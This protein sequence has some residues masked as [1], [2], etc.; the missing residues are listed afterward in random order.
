[1]VRDTGYPQLKRYFVNMFNMPD[2]QAA[3]KYDESC[4]VFDLFDQVIQNAEEKNGLDILD[5]TLH[6]LALAHR[7]NWVI[8]RATISKIIWNS[9]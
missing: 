3:D 1:M 7:N 5:L 2:K 4:R 6:K 9:G 8:R